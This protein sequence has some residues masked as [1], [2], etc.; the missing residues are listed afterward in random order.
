MPN[1]KTKIVAD[2]AKQELFIV[3]EFDAPRERVFQ[4]FTDSKTH[5]QWRGPR[6]F[7][8]KLE[9]FEPY[10]NGGYRIT[11]TDPQ[12]NNFFFHGVYHEVMAPERII[13]TFEYDNLP[14]KGHVELE[15][16]RFEELLGGRT[17]VTTQVVYQSVADR[18]AMYGSGMEQG[19]IEGYE[20]LDE[21]L[22]KQ[23]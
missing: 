22:A 21:L 8:M 7:T 20:Q 17:R 11:H 23:S 1:N 4:A 18:D 6:G 9:K 16:V 2:P 5:A 13:S 15:T 10:S 14:E 3:R 12:G 19:L